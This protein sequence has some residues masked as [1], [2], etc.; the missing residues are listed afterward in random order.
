MPAVVVTGLGGTL[1][2]VDT[3]TSGH[4]IE[5]DQTATQGAF[6]VEVDSSSVG[7]FTGI[8]NI[9][10]DLFVDSDSLRF[11][12]PSS[13]TTNLRGDLT[14]WAAEP[15]D[16]ST[17]VYDNFYAIKGDVSLTEGNGAD[18][19]AVVGYYASASIGGNLSIT[20]GY[21]TR[22]NAIV[23]LNINGVRIGGNVSITQGCGTYDLIEVG[24][25]ASAAIGGNLFIAQGYGAYD[26]AIVGNNINSVSIGGNLS[27]TQ[28]NGAD[29]FAGVGIS[30]GSAAIGGNL[31][32][33]QGNG[34]DD[35]VTAGDDGSTSFG[36]NVFMTQGN[37][38][39]DSVA[40]D[41]EG[42]GFKSTIGRNLFLAEG[43]GN[44]DEIFFDDTTVTGNASFQ[45]GNG[46]SDVV[47]IEAGVADGVAVTF[48]KNVSISF[49]RGGGAS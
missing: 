20:Q 18:D 19:F 22:D 3:D 17:E 4:A 43:D 24:Q 29:D 30:A 49:G 6:T 40:F 15:A 48:T 9:N 38:D 37:G 12:N 45:I 11:A 42:T 14:V 32:I 33:A 8:K 25:F 41:A 27:I 39:Q 34:D 35:D 36:G 28:G 31:F 5:V 26:A 21:G 13:A 16:G 47:Y 46:N 44:A 2:I 7:T 1:Y 10:A 23:G